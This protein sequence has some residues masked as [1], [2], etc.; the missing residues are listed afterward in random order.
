LASLFFRCGTGGDDASLLV[1][2]V[3]DVDGSVGTES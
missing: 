2:C 3:G 1:D